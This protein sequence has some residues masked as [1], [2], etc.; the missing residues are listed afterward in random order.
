MSNLPYIEI[1]KGNFHIC[2]G[3][4]SLKF[5]D[6]IVT[7]PHSSDRWKKP[8]FLFIDTNT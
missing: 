8:I 4:Y 6:T 2:G 3:K 5:G 1:A 7:S